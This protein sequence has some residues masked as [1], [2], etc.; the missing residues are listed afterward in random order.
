MMLMEKKR[1]SLGDR[2]FHLSKQL[3]KAMNHGIYHALVVDTSWEQ[4]FRLDW[5]S[6]GSTIIRLGDEPDGIYYLDAGRVKAYNANSELLSVMEE[7]D[8]FGEMAYF[9]GER[10]RT[11]TVVA[12]SNVVVR[13]ISTEDFGRLPLII[14]IF[15]MIAA[16][17]KE[18]M[19]HRNGAAA[20]AQLIQAQPVG[21]P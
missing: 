10:R 7:G 3:L 16:A 17:R 18:K 21:G 12:D 8:I 9:G 2:L 13:K 4:L 15:K 19:A 11:A 14:E 5:H 20:G 6:K 1:D